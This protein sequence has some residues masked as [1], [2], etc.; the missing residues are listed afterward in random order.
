MVSY[1][2]SFT[3]LPPGFCPLVSL[4]PV[5]VLVERLVP[6][7]C[8]GWALVS[9]FFLGKKGVASAMEPLTSGR[10]LQM[11]DSLGRTLAAA[12]RDGTAPNL[13]ETDQ[14]GAFPISR[15]SV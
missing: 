10:R 4:F 9:G 15:S 12:T 2:V 5:L 7:S 13:R 1:G 11:M 3:S 8:A 6:A 14:L